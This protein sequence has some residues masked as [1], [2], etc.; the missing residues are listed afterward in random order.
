LLRRLLGFRRPARVDAGNST[1]SAVVGS[2]LRW[3][4]W[5]AVLHNGWWLVTSVYLVADAGLS[6]SQ[7]VLIGAA[8]GAVG[9]VF[10]V[11][12]GVIADTIGRRPSLLVS[13]ALM[14]GAMIATGLVAGF[15][16]LVATQML[17]GLS[18]TFASGA[19]VAWITDELDR[20]AQI[21]AVLVRAGRAQLTGAAAGVVGIGGLS[22]LLQRDTVMQLAGLAML[23]LGLYVAVRFREERFVAA[24]ANRWATLWT[25]LVRGSALAR[26]SRTILL[27]VSATL[28]VNAATVGSGR[29]QPL[30][31]I[32]LGLPVDPVVW[33]ATLSVLA[34]AVG[35]A[36]LRVVE[37]YIDNRDETVHGY[38]LA[39]AAGAAGVL[40]FAVAPEELSASAAVL[41]VSGIAVPVTR[42]LSTVWVNRETT[43]D[44]R[45][46]VHSFLAQAEYVG[47]IG[48]GL[49][50]AA[51]AWFAGA[52]AALG[53]C[54]AL[55]AL[56]FVLVRRG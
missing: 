8:Q 1:T 51:V 33:F 2:F 48:G 44:V 14:G 41:L 25:I 37:S 38:L 32:D 53:G 13:H 19:D 20:P 30:R 17:W 9:L 49:A 54:A 34:L 3:T 46:T 40:V 7:L 12:A 22:V 23:L 5:R 43:T 28:L 47:E 10:E 45:A 50:I 35:A 18:W 42:V 27:V 52:S 4:W 11:P 6:A 31:L 16:A 21:S 39:C 56:T 24:S 15:A 26:R 55:F 36:V 29:I